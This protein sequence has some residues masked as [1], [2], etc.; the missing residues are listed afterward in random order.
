MTKNKVPNQIHRDLMGV[1]GLNPWDGHDS[2]S[3][4][5]MI[6]SHLSQMLVI[7]HPTERRCQTG[8]ER[9]YGKYTFSIKMPVDAEVIRVIERYPNKIGLGSIAMNPQRIILF[10]D[11]NT[12]E[13]GMLNIPNYCSYHQYFGFEYKARPALYDAFRA[14]A[15]IAKDT[16]LLDSPS[17]TNDGGYR[18][19]RECNIAYMSH[20]AVSEDG[21]LICEDVLPMFSFKSYETRVV[22]FGNKRFP[23]NLYADIGS[24]GVPLNYKPFPDI[25]D[26]VHEDGLLMCLRSYDRELAVVEQGIYDSMEPDFIFDKATYAT[27]KGRIVDIRVHHDTRNPQ[28]GTPA[29]MAEQPEKYDLA[30]RQFY[31]D[32]VNEYNRL[33]RERGDALRITPELHRMVVEALSVIDGGTQRI[34]KLYRQAPLDDWR[35]EFVIEYETVPTIGFKFT[36]LHGNS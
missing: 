8:M 25:G 9:E 21:I 20:P 15:A 19:G 16:I 2:S 35:L 33:R 36:G 3:R 6:G 1:S 17:I 5:Q 13:I 30:R 23:L 4:K 11:I 26:Y 12:K 7:S 24:D 22:E 29:G 32:I 34:V 14:G 31:Q 10:E 28:L 27:P 18:F